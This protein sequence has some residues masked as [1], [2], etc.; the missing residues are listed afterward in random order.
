MGVFCR[1]TT[2]C[3]V[4]SV[5]LIT[6]NYRKVPSNTELYRKWTKKLAYKPCLKISLNLLCIK[7][8]TFC[9][10]GLSVETELLMWHVKTWGGKS[11][12]LLMC[13][14]IVL[15]LIVFSLLSLCH[16]GICHGCHVD[17]GWWCHHHA[18]TVVLVVMSLWHW[19]SVSCHC[20]AYGGVALITLILVVLVCDSCN[21]HHL[22]M[23]M[24]N[25]ALLPLWYNVSVKCQLSLCCFPAAS[26]SPLFLPKPRN[27]SDLMARQ[28]ASAKCSPEAEK[29]KSST[30]GD[31][32]QSQ[33]QEALRVQHSLCPLWP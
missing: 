22:L 13:V 23:Q 33:W 26:V 6:E 29:K 2:L 32:N 7:K 19:P 21:H 14:L 9:I 28:K 31:S 17:A 11:A 8:K 24:W 25:M 1:K 10:L 30:S 27:H 5:Q 18:A 4:E 12:V 20:W 16:H 3:S 15:A